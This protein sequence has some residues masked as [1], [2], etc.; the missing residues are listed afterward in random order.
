M[1]RERHDGPGPVKADSV[2]PRLSFRES[3]IFRSIYRLD[4]NSADEL[5]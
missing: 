5:G 3:V 1:G 4:L 2:R